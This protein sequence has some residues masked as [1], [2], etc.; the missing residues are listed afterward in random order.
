MMASSSMRR[1]LAVVKIVDSWMLMS[2]PLMSST[3]CGLAQNAARPCPIKVMAVA[4]R[5]MGSHGAENFPICAGGF[6]FL[7]VCLSR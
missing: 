2:V 3:N 7:V 5:S 1:S 4:M 6:V